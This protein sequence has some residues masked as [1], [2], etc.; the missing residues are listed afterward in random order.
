MGLIQVIAYLPLIMHGVHQVPGLYAI[1]Y[2]VYLQ[3]KR[4]GTLGEGYSGPP[5]PR[6][7]PLFLRTPGS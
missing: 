1:A 6:P 4:L 7:G 2:G 5:R 3:G